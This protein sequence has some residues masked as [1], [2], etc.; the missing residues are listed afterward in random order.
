MSLEI[1]MIIEFADVLDENVTRL[2]LPLEF[3]AF[4]IPA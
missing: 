1:V 3:F 2:P 4:F